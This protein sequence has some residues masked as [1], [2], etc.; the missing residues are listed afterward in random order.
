MWYM[1]SK[2]IV[3]PQ[4]GHK[5]GLPTKRAGRAEVCAAEGG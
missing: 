2:L 5:G 1:R 4:A 3:N